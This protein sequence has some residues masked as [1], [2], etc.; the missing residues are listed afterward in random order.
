MGYLVV[1]SV[2]AHDTHHHVVTHL[3]RFSVGENNTKNLN[4]LRSLAETYQQNT[5][6][7]VEQ[8]MVMNIYARHELRFRSL[9]GRY[10]LH[11]H[12]KRIERLHNI[13]RYHYVNFPLSGLLPHL[14]SEYTLSLQPYWLYVTPKSTAPASHYCEVRI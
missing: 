7:V 11:A 2:S 1:D 10:S 5:I 9:L 14:A 6:L 8:P 12:P 4:H 13:M 3:C